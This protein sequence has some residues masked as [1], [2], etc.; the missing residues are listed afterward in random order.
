MK[1]GVFVGTGCRWQRWTGNS[2]RC[3][4]IRWYTANGQDSHFF[5]KPSRGWTL[6]I[7]VSICSVTVCYPI[8]IQ[9]LC[10]L[11]QDDVLSHQY[12]KEHQVYPRRENVTFTESQNSADIK[13]LISCL[14]CPSTDGVPPVT[15]HFNRTAPACGHHRVAKLAAVHWLQHQRMASL[16]GIHCSSKQDTLNTHCETVKT[17]VHCHNLLLLKLPNIA[18]IV[19]VI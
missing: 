10:T 6:N 2:K 14:G 1:T 12:C 19:N 18:V 16:A 7:T 15:T 11:H 8:Y 9:Y 3:H 13:Q 17:A 4:D 5:I